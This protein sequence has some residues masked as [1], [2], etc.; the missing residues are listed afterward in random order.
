M[1]NKTIF[2]AIVVVV[3]MFAIAGC[4]GEG[5][6]TVTSD[7]VDGASTSGK[8]SGGTTSGGTTSGGTTSGGTTSGGT[9]SGGTTSG[10]TTSGG[11]TSGGTTSGGT[12]SGGTTGEVDPIEAGDLV[13]A[14]SYKLNAVLAALARHVVSAQGACQTGVVTLSGAKGLLTIQY[15]GCGFPAYG[16]GIR[17]DGAVKFQQS[18]STVVGGGVKGAFD[19]NGLSITLGGLEQATLTGTATLIKRSSP[20]NTTVEWSDVEMT[21][22]LKQK[23]N[24]I[25]K[26]ALEMVD[27]TDGMELSGGYEFT[28][29]DLSEAVSIEMSTASPLKAAPFTGFASAGEIRGSGARG[30]GL[31][32][33]PVSAS[34]VS[35][36][37]GG[38]TS[39]DAVAWL[40]LL[41]PQSLGA[42]P[43]SAGGR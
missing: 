26:G 37:V 8:D 36:L 40:E 14:R 10:G 21:F 7:G 29:T 3:M 27:G 43:P 32:L 24:R 16:I 4:G 1:N 11:T 41:F 2:E 23:N 6:L 18:K 13:L 39:K 33:T 30:G 35:T 20:G 31:L 22:E 5:L 15:D 25:G 28:A 38:T 42:P 17:F 9:T 34:A 12:T 19:A